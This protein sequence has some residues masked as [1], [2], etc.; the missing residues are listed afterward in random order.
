MRTLPL[1]LALSLSACTLN[2]FYIDSRAE[3]AK[4]FGEDLSGTLQL[5]AVAG[6]LSGE[7]GAVAWR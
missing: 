1:V 2:D 5:I 6:E 3:A 7:R 4:V